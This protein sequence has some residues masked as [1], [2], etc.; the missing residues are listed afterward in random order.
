MPTRSLQW[1]II[2]FYFHSRLSLAKWQ[3]ST[4]TAYVFITRN[5]KKILLKG[6]TRTIWSNYAHRG[7]LGN[8][9]QVPKAVW[10]ILPCG[11]L[12]RF[13]GATTPH[14]FNT[15]IQLLFIER[16]LS[17]QKSIRSTWNLHLFTPMMTLKNEQSFQ[18]F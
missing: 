8:F 14:A 11:C 4:W 10:V 17:K 1:P 13:Q 18:Y 5:G 3:R 6:K 16:P 9:N 7:I 12:Q 2:N 15:I